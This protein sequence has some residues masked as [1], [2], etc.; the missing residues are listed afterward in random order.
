[1]TAA[2]DPSH[3][4]NVNA[5]AARTAQVLALVAVLAGTLAVPLGLRAVYR[6]SPAAGAPPSY[7]P[8]LEPTRVR[9]MPFDANVAA[10]LRSLEPEF[11]FVGDSMVGSRIDPAYLS[12][13]LGDRIVAGI[14]HT[15]TGSAFWYLA[16]KNWI[17]PSLT[18][19]KVVF[20]FFR[21]ENLTDPMFRVTGPYRPNLDRA[22][23]DREPVLNEILAMHTQGPWFRVHGA[24]EDVYRQDAVRSWLEPGLAQLPVSLVAR[25]KARPRL[26]ERINEEVFALQALRQMAPADM[27]QADDE[28]Y[29]F[30]RNLPRSILPEMLKVARRGGVGL[31][32][33]RV[34]RRPE[35]NKPPPQSPA[36]QRY[37]RDLKAYLEANGA[38]FAD[39]WGDPDQ[40]LSIY[41]DG[42]HISREGRRP[43]TE[44]FLRKHPAFFR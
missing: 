21:D 38:F 19:P 39:D 36:L 3:A 17:V 26:L 43:Y 28:A 1:V 22:A 31:A 27:A 6:F 9:E 32:F 2:A 16:L 13:L 5:R 30:Q 33:V 44:Q 8:A 11:I 25:P 40:P 23:R 14:F 29:D 37:M 35:G 4:S 12:S 7:L 42:D 18:R 41:A 34:Q 24:L 20:F 10:D 15:A